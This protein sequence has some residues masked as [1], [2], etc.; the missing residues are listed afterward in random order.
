MRQGSSDEH[1][2][3][4]AD[5]ARVLVAED[6]DAIRKNLVRL[7]KIEGYEVFVA[8]NGAEAINLAREHLPDIVLSDVMMPV[9]DGHGLLAALRADPITNAIPLIFLT[10]KG[11]HSDVREGMNMGADD[12]V[13]K[14]FQREELLNTLRARLERIRLQKASYQRLQSEAKRLLHY[15]SLTC[16]PNRAWL[17]ARI[18]MAMSHCRRN[19]ST[20]ALI[21]IG[22]DGFGRVN[23]A[24]GRDTGD[25]LLREAAAR[26]QAMVDGA[27]LAGS[28][29]NVARLSGDEFGVLIEGFGGLGYLEP[30]SVALIREVSRPMLANERDVFVS[31]CAGIAIWDGSS[32]ADAASFAQQA[33][34]ALHQAKGNGPGSRV[35]YSAEIS[36]AVSRRI[37]LEHAL[38][39]ALAT[40]QLSLHYQPQIDIATGKIAGCEA[41]MRWQHP[42]L[43]FVSPAEFIPVAEESGLIVSM[44][45]WA[46]NTACVQGKQWQDTGLHVRVAVNLSAKQVAQDG[47]LAEVSQALKNSGLPPDLL[48]LEITESIAMQDVEMVIIT[49]AALKSL[50]IALAMDD[51]GTG[52]SSLS[53][54]K[55]L[56][57][58]VL[59]VDQSFVRNVTTDPGDAAITRA[60]VAMAH[61]FG[62]SVIAEGVE[63]QAH[64]DYL[65]ALG[66]EVAQGYL[67]SKPLPAEQATEFFRQRLRP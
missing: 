52:Y 7:L 33:E 39:Q 31:A 63:T 43:G 18:E 53:Y 24:M 58:D 56:P 15:D 65:A 22:L 25:R 36:K 55:R 4:L 42:E 46:L 13:T 41:L 20:M 47:I 27:P 48:E 61:S 57:L 6:D 62:M 19:Q 14:P 37:V 64:Y 11:D 35:F 17:T 3:T 50:G 28:F 60:V 30:Y 29:D 54:L 23:D 40:N 34:A 51:F 66:C 45:T 67:F 32:T 16:L 2:D 8:E 5:S 49:L 9:M 59:K 26:L 1:P 44:G 10:A 21:L 12:Y 38:H